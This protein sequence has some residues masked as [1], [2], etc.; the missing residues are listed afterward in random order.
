MAHRLSQLPGKCENIHGHSWWCELEIIGEVND[1]G[2]ILDFAY[3]KDH[4]RKHLDSTLDHRLLLNHRDILVVEKI[5][6]PGLATM[7]G[8]PTTEN[9]ANYIGMW[10]EGCFG[11]KYQYKVVVWETSVNCATWTLSLIHI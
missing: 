1:S 2:I 4:F 11:F 10:A 6:L 3:V 8:D 9:I 7:A 5:P